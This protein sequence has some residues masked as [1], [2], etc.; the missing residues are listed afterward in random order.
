[1]ITS[2]MKQ[3]IRLISTLYLS[4]VK[5]AFFPKFTAEGLKIIRVVA[6]TGI[7]STVFE[8]FTRKHSC[9]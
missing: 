1:M 7:S 3:K 8:G 9:L 5:Y 4:Q 2:D 6:T